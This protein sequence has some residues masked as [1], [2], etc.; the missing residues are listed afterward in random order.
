MCEQRQHHDEPGGSLTLIVCW[1]VLVG[2]KQLD[3]GEA[4]HVVWSS[5]RLMLVHVHCT[6]G[7]DTLE[8]AG[9][10][11]PFRGELL[12]VTAPRRCACVRCWCQEGGMFCRKRADS[13]GA[14]KGSRLRS[15]KKGRV[16]KQ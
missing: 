5:Q 15:K 8:N 2:A 10:L 3:G 14:V 4:L 13:A 7:D 12:A 6:H 9:R 11:G 16:A 1:L